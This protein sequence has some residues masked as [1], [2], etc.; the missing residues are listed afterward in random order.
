MLDLAR[1]FD[2]VLS[3]IV[4]HFFSRGEFDTIYVELARTDDEGIRL[5]SF[6]QI[7]IYISSILDYLY[8]KWLKFTAESRVLNAFDSLAER[9]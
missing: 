5:L 6:S 9:I 2:R 7:E 1:L 8:L 4:D 3:W